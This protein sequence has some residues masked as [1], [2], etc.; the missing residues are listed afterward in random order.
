MS[1]AAPASARSGSSEGSSSMR[2]L[3]PVPGPRRSA[4]AASARNVGARRRPGRAPRRPGRSTA[5]WAPSRRMARSTSSGADVLAALP[6]RMALRVAQ[7]AGEAPVLA[8]A[9]AAVQLDGERRPPRRRG[10]TGGPWPRARGCAAGA[11]RRRAA[12]RRRTR[13]RA[14]TPP[15]ARRARSTSCSRASGRSTSRRP[16]A[17]RWWAQI[18]GLEEQRRAMPRPIMATPKRDPLTIS[19]MRSEPA[20]VGAC[21]PPLV[22]GARGAAGRS[23]ARRGTRPRRS[24]RSSCRASA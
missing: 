7:L 17:S 16:L 18:G 1:R 14:R 23:R 21:R 10:G 5:S 22:G 20:G 15:R 19:I 6:D 9:V 12:S 3:E 8:V 13:S 2:A 24:A 11:R 4:M